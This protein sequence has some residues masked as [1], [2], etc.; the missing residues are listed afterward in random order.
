MRYD[1]IFKDELEVDKK[2]PACLKTVILKSK[3]KRC[4]GSM[5]IA[6]GKGPHPTI[7][8]LHGFPGYEQN[9]DLAQ[10][11]RRIGYNVLIFHYRGSWGN[12][13]DYSF[14]DVL[15]DVQ[16]SMEFLNSEEALNE[17]RVDK[18]KITLIGHSMGGFAALMTAASDFKIKAAVSISGFNLGAFAES[19]YS[20]KEKIN[21]SIEEWIENIY[22]LNGTC[23]KRLV[24][25]ALNNIHKY[26][27]INYADRLSKVPLLLI[28]GTR[29]KDAP[30]N[31]HHIPL[32]NALKEKNASA[33]EEVILDS[34]H[35]FS[36]RRISLIQAVVS[37]LERHQ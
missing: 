23:S 27:I 29:D 20:N 19:I 10:V 16:V 14:T 2:Y 31:I 33:L 15:E 25:E 5:Y 12:E 8:L 32:V 18:S 3:E 1:L 24:N 37:W 7:N 4:V 26:N 34:D 28:G 6:Q 30:I 22:P 21:K 9:I 11:L 36:D 35:A 13:G 17:Y